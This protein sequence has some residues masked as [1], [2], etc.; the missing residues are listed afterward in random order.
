VSNANRSWLKWSFLSA[1]L[2]SMLHCG[3]PTQDQDESSTCEEGLTITKGFPED[4][5]QRFV[6]FTN[7]GTEQEAIKS[8]RHAQ[9]QKIVNDPRYIVQLLKM[10][11]PVE[12]LPTVHAKCR[13]RRTSEANGGSASFGAVD[14][15]DRSGRI[16][17]ADGGDTAL[18]TVDAESG[19]G[20]NSEVDGSGASQEAVDTESGS[21][22]NSEADGGSASQ[23]A[24]DARN[25]SG[26]TH[27]ADG[28]HSSIETSEVTIHRDWSQSLGGA[29][30]ATGHYPAKYGF[31]YTTASCSD[32]VVFPTAQ[33]GASNKA[34]II[35][36]NNVYVGT[37][38]CNAANP[39]VYWAYNTGT[40]ATAKLSPVLS[41]DGTQVAFIQ[42]TS[43]VASLVMLKMASSGGAY[44]SP[45]SITSVTNANYRSCTAPCYTTIALNGNPND[46]YSAP[47]YVYYTDILFVGD[48]SG[49]VHR[50]TNIF[51]SG[52]P[53]E[54]TSGGWP[55]TVS[56]KLNP[57]LNSPVYDSGA[58][59]RIFVADHNSFFYSFTAGATP[60][61]VGASAQLGDWYD[62][63]ADPPL[64]D[65]TNQY[66][67]VFVGY[68]YI[69]HANAYVYRFPA[70]TALSGGSG[71]YVS[72]NGHSPD[73]STIM[74]VGAFDNQFRT[75]NGSTG[76]LYACSNG[77][78]VQIPMSGFSTVNAF[79][80]P[81]SAMGSASACSPITEFLGTVASTT[82][83]SDINASTTSVAV[84]STTGMAVND[85]VQIDSE[86]MKITT[87]ANPLTVTRGQV[88]TTAAAHSS[89]ATTDDVKDWLFMSVIGWGNAGGCSGACM[90]NYN[91]MGAGTTGSVVAALSASGGTSGII[92]D[93]KSMTQTGART[94]Y[95][96]TLTGNNAVQ[97]TQ[98][99]LN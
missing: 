60:G 37:G 82:I 31:D 39:S 98:S 68:G 28:G 48:D 2:L 93:N 86:I 18:V 92:V 21:G 29:G 26:R 64:V 45:A 83:T 57:K 10:K 63:I 14:A 38:G 47:F 6:V 24:A 50:F 54:T 61:S 90:Y 75:G 89:G 36:F 85:Y 76:N 69:N 13:S 4:W 27:K 80:Q 66:V 19:S 17:K 72:F 16:S 79:N 42:V 33:L 43:N 49:K 46:T 95:Y 96:N 7:P 55:V 9:W 87:L 52:T 70:G 65:S 88:G 8:G 40:N 77:K 22:Q 3:T 58:S 91:V 56:S 41:L 30:L 11:M 1:A 74:R 51:L 62:M 99:G 73:T 5:S 15:Q 12:G 34:T 78:M 35:A 71:T 23:E 20:Q 59:G 81:V 53:A 94:V 44:N 25:T 67:Y 84:G 32:Y 97:A